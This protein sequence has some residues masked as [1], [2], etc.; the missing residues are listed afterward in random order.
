MTVSRDDAE[1]LAVVLIILFVTVVI[2][3]FRDKKK[4]R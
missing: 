1:F 4:D 3:A 2:P